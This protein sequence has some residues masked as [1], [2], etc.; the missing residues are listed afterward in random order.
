MSDNEDKSVHEKLLQALYEY[1]NAHQWWERKHSVRAGRETRKQLRN[2]V[3]L[4]KERRDEIFEY[5]KNNPPK[6]RGDNIS[7]YNSELKARGKDNE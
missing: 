2:I 4:A 3:D 7:K 5:E 1:F 6:P